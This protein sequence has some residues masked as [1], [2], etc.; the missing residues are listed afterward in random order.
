MTTTAIPASPPQIEMMPYRQL[1][2]RGRSYSLV[3]PSIRDPRIHLSSVIVT[4]LVL[5]IAWL[6]FQISIAQI[7]VTMLTCATIEL[8]LTF[9]R[10]AMLVWPASALQTGTSTALLLRVVGTQNGDYW[11]LRGWYIF[12][13]VAAFGLLTKYTIR[14]RSG[15]VF[16][17]SNVA[18]VLA[19]I[20]LGSR[21]VEPLDFWWAPLGRPMVAAYVVILVG[22]L[23]ICSRLGLIG[24]GLAFWGALASGIGV[25]ALLNHSITV[26]W[27]LMPARGRSLLVDHP[28]LT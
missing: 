1:R 22:G 21:R 9:K 16:N 25:L 20:I 18:L 7:L 5:G 2:V 13:G 11:T 19:F 28:H 27:S 3:P 6:N 15:H 23:F 8:V 10:T 4:I 24:M 26:R 12:A 14:F 17:P